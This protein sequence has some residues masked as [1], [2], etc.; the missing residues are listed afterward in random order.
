MNKELP[1]EIIRSYK[2]KKTVQAK[3]VD[4]K[5]HV[6]LPEGLS[7]KRESELIEKMVAK[8]EKKRLKKE[9]I[10]GEDYL[11]TCFNE[12]NRK[13]F[14]GE[15]ELTSIKYVTNQNACNGSCTPAKGTIRI[16]HRLADMPKWVLDYLIMHEMAHLLYPDHSKMFW[17]KVNEYQYTERARGFLICKG[18]EKGD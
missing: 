17:D 11:N 15:L 18:M 13:H 6:Y 1:V 7:K 8:V 10:N 2:R 9:L 4:D 3:I 12:F 16:S 5:L 14:N